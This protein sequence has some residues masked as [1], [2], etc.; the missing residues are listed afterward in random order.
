VTDEELEFIRQ[1]DARW[2]DRGR[3]MDAAGRHR[4]L[5]LQYLDELLPLLD[6]IEFDMKAIRRLH[7][8]RYQA[9]TPSVPPEAP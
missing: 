2:V 9:K 5:L 4:R 6:A 3:S 8:E 1:S 7:G